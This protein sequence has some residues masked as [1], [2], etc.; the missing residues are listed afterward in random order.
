[1]RRFIAFTLVAVLLCAFRAAA[2]TFT[3]EKTDRG[4]TVNSVS[5]FTVIFGRSVRR[6]PP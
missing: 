2:A 5:F 4:V 3:A 1:M 6:D